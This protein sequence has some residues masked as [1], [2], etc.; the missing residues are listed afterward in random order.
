MKPHSHTC[1]DTDV[2]D[3]AM[4]F[5]DWLDFAVGDVLAALELDQILLPVDDPEHAVFIN[6]SDVAG[7]E[8]PSV[9]AIITADPNQWF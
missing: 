8:P 5:E 2:L 6:L 3:G 1:V 7:P 9:Q 4:C